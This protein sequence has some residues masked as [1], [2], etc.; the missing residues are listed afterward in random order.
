MSY[1]YFLINHFDESFNLTAQM[2]RVYRQDNHTRVFVTKSALGALIF[3]SVHS[4]IPAAK[5]MYIYIPI[6]VIDNMLTIHIG[7]CGMA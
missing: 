6:K 1:F 3:L 4:Q 7:P 5:L 2:F